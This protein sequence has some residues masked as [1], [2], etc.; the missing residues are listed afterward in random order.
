MKQKLKEIAKEVSSLKHSDSIGIDNFY[1]EEFF[2]NY[3]GEFF[4]SIIKWTEYIFNMQKSDSESYGDIDFTFERL[5]NTPEK[6]VLYLNNHSSTADITKYLIVYEKTEY[7]TFFHIRKVWDDKQTDYKKNSLYVNKPNLKWY[8]DRN[9]DLKFN[10]KLKSALQCS[11][12]DC[13]DSGFVLTAKAYTFTKDAPLNWNFENG[14]I[15]NYNNLKFV[16]FYLDVA[17]NELFDKNDR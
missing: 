12:G 15:Y 3:I 11:Y 4:P 9:F 14:M 17:Y 2:N 7:E 10:D 5:V 8:K 1:F 16:S 6:K 13:R